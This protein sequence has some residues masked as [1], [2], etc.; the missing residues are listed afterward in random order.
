MSKRR[1]SPAFRLSKVADFDARRGCRRCDP[2]G[3]GVSFADRPQ[4]LADLWRSRSG[5][6]VVRFSSQGYV[7][8]LE[9]VRSDDREISDDELGAFADF[10][11]DALFQWAIDG[12]DDRPEACYD[13]SSKN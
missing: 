5:R 3:V 11:A 8:H 6:L 1:T 7:Y 10:V 13:R 4:A 2:P 12:V 9:A